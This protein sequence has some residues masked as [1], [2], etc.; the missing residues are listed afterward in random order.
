MIFQRIHSNLHFE[1]NLTL[2]AIADGWDPRVNGPHMAASVEAEEN[3]E[4]RFL[5]G[6]E[7]SGE[8]NNTYVIYATS[9]TGW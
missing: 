1:L 6:G 5:T 8:G 4:H 3:F 7:V 2:I 9:R